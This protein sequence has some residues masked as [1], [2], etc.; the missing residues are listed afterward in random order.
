M[1]SSMALIGV[2]EDLAG[3]WEAV[4]LAILFAAPSEFVSPEIPV[5]PKWNDDEEED[6]AAVRP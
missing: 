1:P 4:W 3:W 2:L 6:V 5:G